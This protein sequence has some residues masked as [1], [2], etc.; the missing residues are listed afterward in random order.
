MFFIRRV[1]R[2]EVP[3]TPR[4]PKYTTAF[5]CHIIPTLVILICTVFVLSVH[6]RFAY[7]TNGVKLQSPSIT[8]T[9]HNQH[10]QQESPKEEN[11][12]EVK[13][14]RVPY[15]SSDRNRK[16]TRPTDLP[17][18]S[19]VERINDSLQKSVKSRFYFGGGGVLDD[20]PTSPNDPGYVLR[21]ASR[22]EE[23]PQNGYKNFKRSQV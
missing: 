2:H 6:N 20:E 15:V 14:A 3:L 23:Q 13:N 11:E 16:P 17:L 1:S 7:V 8:S 10:K 9:V 18:K 5:Q 21:T 22:W 12:H 19:P 4:K